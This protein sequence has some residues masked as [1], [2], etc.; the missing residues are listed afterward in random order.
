MLVFDASSIIHAWDNYPIDQFPGLW[1]WMADQIEN[2]ELVMPKVAFEEVIIKLPECAEWLKE[3]NIIKLEI[4]TP[5]LQEAL[6]IKKMIGIVG[7]NYHPKG[8]D[9]NDILIIATAYTHRVELVSNEGR[10]K[11]QG[12]P[13]KM[14]IPLVCA[15]NKINVP[16]INFIDFIKRSD[17]VFR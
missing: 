12:K 8:V 1:E 11:S 2:A 13:A 16:C 3:K 9:E 15:M 14:K 4:T 7:D 6:R 10:Q 5:I 17:Q